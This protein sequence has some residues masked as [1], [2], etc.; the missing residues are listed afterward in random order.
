MAKK[1]DLEETFWEFQ[2]CKKYENQ[3]AKRERK[4]KKKKIQE[5]DWL[6]RKFRFS[7]IYINFLSFLSEDSLGTMNIFRKTL[8]GEKKNWEK[9]FWEKKKK[10]IYGLD[11]LLRP[12]YWKILIFI[13]KKILGISEVKKVWKSKGLTVMSGFYL[14]FVET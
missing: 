8:M 1:Y 5:F 14:E 12:L 10:K 9:D 3:K 4:I 6:F 11:F 13:L 2:N 7:Q